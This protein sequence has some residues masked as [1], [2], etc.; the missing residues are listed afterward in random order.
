MSLSLNV[1][2]SYSSLQRFLYFSLSYIP[3]TEKVKPLFFL[4]YQGKEICEIIRLA[5]AR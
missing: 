1:S 4:F 5:L 2:A 3:S